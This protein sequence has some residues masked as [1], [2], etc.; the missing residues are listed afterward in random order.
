MP[1]VRRQRVMPNAGRGARSAEQFCARCGC[2]DKPLQKHHWAPRAVFEDADDWPLSLL[3]RPC[4]DL[5]HRKMGRRPRVKTMARRRT[6]LL[7]EARELCEQLENWRQRGESAKANFV[8]AYAAG[9]MAGLITPMDG[10]PALVVE[11]ARWSEKGYD[12]LCKELGR[13]DGLRGG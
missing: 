1:I 10:Y 3:C 8:W 9:E 5:W 13:L 7:Q 6:A 2:R 12:E 4:H 11:A